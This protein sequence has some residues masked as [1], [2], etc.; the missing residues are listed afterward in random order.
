MEGEELISAKLRLLIHIGSG[1]WG[2]VRKQE[3]RVLSGEGSED[4]PTT[5]Q[6]D[7]GE[8]GTQI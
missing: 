3:L 5:S 1:N 4:F 6:N 7:S 8:V 2:E